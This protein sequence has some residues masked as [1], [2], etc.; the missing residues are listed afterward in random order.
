MLTYLSIRD[1]ILI[2][3]IDLSF[4]GGFNVLTGETGA[5]K[6]IIAD[7]LLV[8]LG[9]RVKS[10]L[11]RSGCEKASIQGT[12]NLGG[13]KDI[14]NGLSEIGL[15]LE[16]NELIVKRE[17]SQDGRSRAFCNG[18]QIPIATLK[19]LGD[20]LAD[21][22][23]QH[24]HQSLMKSET[25][26]VLIDEY[27]NHTVEVLKYKEL[28]TE[29]KD[30]L[31]E[32]EEI[33]ARNRQ[34]KER[35]A[36]L[37]HRRK[38]LQDAG[39]KAGAEAALLTKIRRLEGGAKMAELVNS[40]RESLETDAIGALRRSFKLMQ[41]LAELDPQYSDRTSLLGESLATAES[42]LAHLPSQEAEES[43]ET[44]D[45]LNESLAKI[46]KLKRKYQ[47]DESELITLLS[48]TEEAFSFLD[49][50]VIEIGELEKKAEQL[51]VQV[52]MAADH[53]SGERKKS[54]LRFEKEVV[55]NLKELNMG[56]S[57]FKAAFEKREIPKENGIDSVEFLFSANPG[58]VPKSLSKTASGG[59]LAR[60]MLSVRAVIAEKDRIPVL[61][62]DE[63]DTGIGGE[64]ADKVGEMLKELGISR[65]VFCVTHSHQIAKEASFHYSVEK[66]VS[67][68]KTTIRVREL[69]K[70]ERVEELARMLG[71]SKKSAAVEHARNLL[72]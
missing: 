51:S 30:A 26:L 46:A 37:E 41:K 14:K 23:G 66:R 59:E 36:L 54:T 65:Q 15:G 47:K 52:H 43:E 55:R 8:L 35:E 42:A 44:L 68:G 40:L 16:D 71:G 31:K 53:L 24:D 72:K 45:E 56:H 9:G 49:K 61:V 62:F 19:S 69:D 22:H 11:I 13:K 29:W 50:S 33:T 2:E 18:E 48:E 1:F 5:G 27:G 21:F 64:T 25:H 34:L 39:I 12:F 20:L 67:G 58:E 6:S 28:F 63:V 10:D 7:A 17:I 38:E 3:K 70:G 4:A 57:V 32:L 60:V